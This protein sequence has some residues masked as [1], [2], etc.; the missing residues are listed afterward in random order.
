MGALDL[1]IVQGVPYSR[2]YRFPG[3]VALWPNAQGC[4][5][6]SQVRH[7]EGSRQLVLNLTPYFSAPSVVAEGE[8]AG[9]DIFTILTLNGDATRLLPPASKERPLIYDVF[10]SDVGSLDERAIRGGGIITVEQAVT[11]AAG[12]E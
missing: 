3:A 2:L 10:I 7:P 4:E 6:R 11:S 12:D 5:I 9:T 8:G 1:E